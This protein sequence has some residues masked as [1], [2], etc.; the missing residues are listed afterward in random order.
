MSF[1]DKLER[2]FGRFA[3]PNL[4]VYVIALSILGNII[5]IVNP[6][7]YHEWFSLDIY[8]ILHGQVWRLVTFCMYPSIGMDAKFIS[9]TVWFVIWAMMY[10][11]IGIAVEQIW[12][13][14]RFNL[15]YFGGAVIVI[16]VTAVT[17]AVMLSMGENPAMLGS[18]LGASATLD[19]LNTSLFLAFAIL[20]PDTEFLIYFII[21]IK[22]KWLA[23][24]YAVLM[25]Y[26]LIRCFRYGLYYVVALIVGTIIN[27][28]LSFLI[29]GRR[30]QGPRAVYKRKKKKVQC[31][32]QVQTG[33]D[34]PR[35]RCAICGR[36]DEDNP[37]LEFR[38]C[39]KCEGN[40]EYCSDHLFT[41][42]HVHR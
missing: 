39:S 12:G 13:T 1:V 40:Y 4:M 33:T 37:N 42:E 5:N 15:F 6:Y 36:T 8:A 14:F 34:G 31:R 28:A 3:I 41:H 21:P 11:Y 2:R 27:L 19:Y 7:V 22:A 16:I 35:H 18:W 26:E 10:Y 30:P 20:S 29:S 9:D 38:Y 17:Y 32:R 24:L 25:G 23:I